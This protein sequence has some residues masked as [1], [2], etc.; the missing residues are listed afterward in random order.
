VLATGKS[1]I[2]NTKK[3]QG[4]QQKNADLEKECQKWEE[5][6][7]E[8][9][10]E[11]IKEEIEEIKKK[12]REKGTQTD[13]WQPT[14]EIKSEKKI[15]SKDTLKVGPSFLQ[16]VGFIIMAIICSGFLILIYEKV[17]TWFK[18][19]KNLKNDKKEN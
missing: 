17:K 12:P 5:E 11:E 3:L 13:K 6:I 2:R 18:E 16:V 7:I 9:I 8:E 10:E 4:E 15:T 19:L 14:V 1:I